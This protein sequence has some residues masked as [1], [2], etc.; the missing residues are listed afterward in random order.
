MAVTEPCS[1]TREAVKKAL[2]VKMTARS[3]DD[4]DRAI[5]AASRAVEGQ[6]HRRF[7]PI[8]ATHFWDWPNY[9]YRSPWTLDFDKWELAAVPTADDAVTTGGQPIPLAEC[10]FEPVN[11][12]PPF[13][14]LELNRSTTAAFGVGP[15]P[16]RDIAIT[17]TFGYD[18]VATPAG[19][20]SAALTDTTGTLVSVANGAAAG[21][22][23]VILV[24][25]ERMLLSDKAAVA[26]G[27]IQ[28][29][30]LAASGA[31]Q[32]IGVSS[33]AGFFVGEVLI[34]DAESVLVT[35]TA[36]ASVTVKR[37][38][39]GTTLATHSAAVIYAFRSWTVTR[40]AFGT[41]TATHLISAPITRYV[42]PSLVQQYALAEAENNLLQGLS[43]YARTVG[44]AD[45]TRPV[46]GQALADIRAQAYAA[47][48]RKGR[49]RTV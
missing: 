41:S 27:Q 3:D 42:V 9:Q 38:W 14:Y 23:D 21:V 19:T 15:T 39:D 16:Q 48:G 34:L 32:V 49:R 30:S 25:G 22:G 6:L 29:G 11:E 35:G 44:S 37:A 4:V 1:V 26:S 13:T 2:D 33:G 46:S 36:P 40:G 28:Q 31:D 47:H 43:G 8:D 7:Y 12:G 20:L 45:N 5:Q 24:D 18:V 10:F 17:G